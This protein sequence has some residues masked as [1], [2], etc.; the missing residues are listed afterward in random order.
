MF[1]ELGGG[2]RAYRKRTQQQIECFADGI[3]MRV[4]TKVFGPLALPS[5]HHHC[6]WPLLIE[7][8]GEKWITLIV[9]K[10]NVEARSMLFD[11]I[12]LQHQRFYFITYFN[13]FHCFGCSNHCRRSG[14]QNTRVLEVVRQ[15]LP[16]VCRFTYVN[17]LAVRIT[18]LVRPR[19][20]WNGAGRW[21]SYHALLLSS[22]FR[23]WLSSFHSLLFRSD[24]L[25]CFG[26]S[27]L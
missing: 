14:M 18:E 10:T 2:T 22:N 26:S 3:G 25:Y 16:Q 21:F 15:S 13:P 11:E 12:E 17:D 24:R 9:T 5:A 19:R 20:F 8:E 6:T 7:R 27:S 4:R 1:F 23:F